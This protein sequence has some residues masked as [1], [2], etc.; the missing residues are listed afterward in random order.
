M[1]W[2]GITEI[3]AKYPSRILEKDD[4]TIYQG[5]KFGTL[6]AVQRNRKLE[7]GTVVTERTESPVDWSAVETATY[8]EIDYLAKTGG[9]V[10]STPTNS[11]G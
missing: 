1:N 3:M 9:K 10:L 2:L 7:D 6:Y 11:A 8:V 5:W 4:G